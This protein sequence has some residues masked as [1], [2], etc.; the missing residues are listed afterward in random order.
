M[1][2]FIGHHSVYLSLWEGVMEGKGRRE[3]YAGICDPIVDS[4][5]LF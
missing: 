1:C 2:C 4:S 5:L 3:D